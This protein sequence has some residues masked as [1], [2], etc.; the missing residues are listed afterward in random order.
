MKTLDER[1]DPGDKIYLVHDGSG[2]I[3]ENAAASDDQASPFVSE[4]APGD[5]D[6]NGG[7]WTHFAAEATDVEA[8]NED[9]LLDTSYIEVTLGRPGFGLSDFF[10]CQLDGRA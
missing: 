1:P 4:S 9:D 3:D 7:K 8:F 2:R 10:V 6:W 5:G